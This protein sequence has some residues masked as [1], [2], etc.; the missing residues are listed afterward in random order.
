MIDV[1]WDLDESEESDVD[2][3]HRDPDWVKT[4]KIKKRRSTQGKGNNSG[5]VKVLGVENK[6]LYITELDSVT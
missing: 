5:Q 2:S 1:E 4:P 3:V 6:L